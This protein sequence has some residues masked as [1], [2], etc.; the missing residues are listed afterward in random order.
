MAK[1]NRNTVDY[2]TISPSDKKN[3]SEKSSL[4]SILFILLF[5][6]LVATIIVLVIQSNEVAS[7]KSQNA[8]LQATIEAL[9]RQITTPQP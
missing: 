2:T 7:L 6:A 5:I 3:N 4:Q 9:Q 1:P 8:L